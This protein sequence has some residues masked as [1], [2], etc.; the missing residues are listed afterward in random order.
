MLLYEQN[1]QT[2]EDNAEEW[3]CIECLRSLTLDRLPKYAP[4]ND[5]WI[6]N[7]PPELTMLTLPE[8]LLISRHYP[9][10]YIVKLFPK[11]KRNIR[12]SD[13]QRAIRGNVTLYNM[14]TNDV[15]KMLEGQ[16]MPQS[17][18]SLSSIIAITYIGTQKLRK[19]WLKSTFRVQRRV[20]HDALLW[21]K[22]HNPLYGDITISME[23]LV[24][25]P[26]DDVPSDIMAI[27]R[28]ENDENVALRESEGY[29]PVDDSSTRG[30]YHAT[31]IKQYLTNTIFS[32]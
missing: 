32:R 27:I 29:I 30:K 21:L 26:E 24:D 9:K 13:L 22:N 19:N 20:V 5:M 25:L 17:V 11:E 16:L 23:R 18:A 10:C 28:H 7:V 15:V 4:T 12:P 6:G 1:L 3:T 2:M 31:C 8:E 14:N